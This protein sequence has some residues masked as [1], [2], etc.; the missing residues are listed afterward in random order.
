MVQGKQK[1][2][3]KK[4]KVLSSKNVKVKIVK[5]TKKYS[6]KKTKPMKTKGIS[7]LSKGIA[8]MAE[9]AIKEKSAAN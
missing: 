6:T 1:L 3:S 2:I 9:N 4:K 8:Q 7:E 5:T